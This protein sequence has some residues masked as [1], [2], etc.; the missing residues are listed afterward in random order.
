MVH[1]IQRTIESLHAAGSCPRL[2]INLS[3]DGVDCPD[4]VREQWNE[5]LIV[6]LD[7]SSGKTVQVGKRR[8]ARVVP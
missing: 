2:Q 8:F 5:R 6:D 4:F 1:R 7:P 3:A